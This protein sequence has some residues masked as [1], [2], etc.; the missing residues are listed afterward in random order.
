MHNA[1]KPLSALATEA[2]LPPIA[3]NFPALKLFIKSNDMTVTDP[4][5]ADSISPVVLDLSANVAAGSDAYNKDFAATAA[6]YGL[7]F[8]SGSFP[9]DGTKALILWVIGDLHATTKLSWG[10]GYTG[11]EDGF[12]LTAGAGK[13]YVDDGVAAKVALTDLALSGKC[14]RGMG[15]NAGMASAFSFE[16]DG[17]IFKY[18][19]SPTTL[20]GITTMAGM[21]DKSHIGGAHSGF[22]NLGV[23]EFA[24]ALPPAPFIKAAMG[25]QYEQA[26]RG[27]NVIYPGLKNAA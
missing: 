4:T 10:E 2:A 11:S 21:P 18:Q 24:A 20:T 9:I 15:I 14:I 6:G 19:S 17:T 22:Y 23:L 8:G 16:Y 26:I 12:G 27:N 3:A 5:V 13:C 1:Q 7:A 25:W